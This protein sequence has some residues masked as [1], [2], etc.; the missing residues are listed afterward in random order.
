MDIS[1]S[2]IYQGLNKRTI[3]VRMT[4]TEETV[5]PRRCKNAD[6]MFKLDLESLNS[7]ATEM[8]FPSNPT[9][10]TDNIMTELTGSGLDNLFMAS[11]IMNPLTKNKTMTFARAASISALL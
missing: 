7:M 3:A 2:R 5:S 1:V 8:P 9:K 11:Y 4:A 10:A 6:F